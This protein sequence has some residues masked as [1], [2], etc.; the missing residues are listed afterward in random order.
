MALA[1]RTIRFI[2]SMLDWGWD[3]TKKKPITTYNPSREDV[4]GEDVVPVYTLYHYNEKGLTETKLPEA[5]ACG[6]K[7]S[8]DVV[9]LN[10]D[11]LKK[12]EVEQISKTYDLHPLVVEDILSTGQRAK[13]D[14]TG[15]V[16]YC[17]L[18]MIYYNEG[19][20]QIEAEQVS[21][22]LG[23][24]FVLSFQEDQTRDVFNPVRDKLRNTGSKLRLSTADYLCYALIDVI[25][26]S[27]FGVLEK[28]NERIEKL[29][30]KI[31]LQQEKAATEKISILRREVMTMR[32]LIA[33]VRELVTGFL[34]SESHLLE[35]SQDKYYK[36]VFDHITQANEYADA[37]RD[38]LI[39]LQDVFTSQLNMR[40]NEVMK[41]FTMVATLLAP[42]TV[43][44]G[45]F[46]MNFDVI[47]FAHQT[48]GFWWAVAAML[49]IPLAMIIWFKRKGWF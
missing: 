45:I 6:V 22:V 10:I 9:W 11:G 2:N 3:F 7:K 37:H 34:R 26:D 24:G 14:E 1:R 16:I 39:N 8:G 19:T 46:G 30:D 5:E 21:I 47:P 42:A 28:M 44:G 48:A 35:Y 23:K 41:I 20:G 4:K 43:I 36:D 40:M 15:D 13:M 18:P 25:V 17:L 27:Y 31:L 38:L 33:P 29:E 49:L 12:D 32:R